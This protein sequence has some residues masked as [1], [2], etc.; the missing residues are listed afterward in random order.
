MEGSASKRSLT[1]MQTRHL[2]LD[3][4]GYQTPPPIR[5]DDAEYCQQV[6]H[7]PAPFTEQDWDNDLQ[8]AALNDGFELPSRVDN[9][10]VVDSSLS[11]VT[12][13][14]ERTN[15]QSSIM[16]PSTAPTSCSSSERRPMA[17]DS[18]ISDSRPSTSHVG[19]RASPT[20]FAPNKRSSIFRSRMRRIV[21][22]RK[23]SSEQEET[24]DSPE[25][26]PSVTTSAVSTQPPQL[27]IAQ[28]TPSVR[29]GKSSWSQ[30]VS[31]G[32][33]HS[34]EVDETTDKLPPCAKLLD[35]Q[36]CQIAEKQRFVEFRQMLI[37]ELR[38]ER[39]VAKAQKKMLFDAALLE[40]R[41]KVRDGHLVLDQILTQSRIKKQWTKWRTGIWRKSCA[42]LT[43]I[44][45]ESR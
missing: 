39:D 9:V 28:Q 1:T 23:R 22:R 26:V 44:V 34:H 19:G 15:L 11:G 31:N 32:L 45:Y 35:L 36:K 41:L 4:D 17:N 24:E 29:S 18:A 25:T 6:R 10:G 30:E 13:H 27:E 40:K 5:F 42:C 12:V 7:I 2:T 20:R 38:R 37:D 33:A 21:G 43:N 14:S 3:D 16:T 8:R